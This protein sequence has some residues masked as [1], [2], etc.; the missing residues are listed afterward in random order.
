MDGI[1]IVLDWKS[2]ISRKWKSSYGKY[3]CDKKCLSCNPLNVRKKFYRSIVSNSRKG[4]NSS[5]IFFSE[6]GAKM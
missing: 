4:L 3:Q 6:F 5:S 2:Q 1:I